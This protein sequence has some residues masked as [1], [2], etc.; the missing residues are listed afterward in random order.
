MPALQADSHG[1]QIHGAPAPLYMFNRCWPGHVACATKTNVF[2]GRAFVTWT[3]DRKYP[4]D[5]AHL[6]NQ[7][8]SC[9]SGCQEQPLLKC[10][11]L[12]N[13]SIKNDFTNITSIMTTVLLITLRPLCVTVSWVQVSQMMSTSSSFLF[14]TCKSCATCTKGSRVVSMAL[15]YIRLDR[16]HSSS[17]L[18]LYLH[19]TQRVTFNLKITQ[20]LQHDYKLIWATFVPFIFMF[21][22]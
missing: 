6:L 22:L 16:S 9:V 14:L 7:Y 15:S 17:S 20:Y 19:W 1:I 5:H 13:T 18:R 8:C 4:E 3:F 21:I 12:L 2:I 10:I 11:E